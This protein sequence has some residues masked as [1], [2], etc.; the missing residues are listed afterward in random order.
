MI[1][2]LTPLFLIFFLATSSYI[3]A[4][5]LQFSCPFQAPVLP[6]IDSMQTKEKQVEQIDQQIDDLKGLR[7]KY[8]AKSARFQ[9]QGDRLQ[10]YDNYQAEARRYWDLSDCALNTVLE[11]DQMIADLETKKQELLKK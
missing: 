10:F 11:I 1:S 8:L 7:E 9:N 2:Y 5:P 6:P 3:F 4:N